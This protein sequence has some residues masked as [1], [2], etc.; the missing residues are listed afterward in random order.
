MKEN[1]KTKQI[2]KQKVNGVTCYLKA[3]GREIVKYDRTG[4]KTIEFQPITYI[5]QASDGYKCTYAD[6]ARAEIGLQNLIAFEKKQ[7]TISEL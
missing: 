6:R 4:D 5:V 3:F 2:S 1:L 7:L